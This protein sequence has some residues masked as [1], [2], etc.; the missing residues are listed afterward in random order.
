MEASAAKRGATGSRS[1]AK[2]RVAKLADAL[3]LGSSGREAVEVQVLSRAPLIGRRAV[4]SPARSFRS[5]G[6]DPHIE[7]EEQ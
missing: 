6:S 1:F 5:P 4:H 2:A 3:D 7:P